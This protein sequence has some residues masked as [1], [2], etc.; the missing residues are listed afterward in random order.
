MSFNPTSLTLPKVGIIL[1]SII[2]FLFSCS[3]DTDLLLDSVLEDNPEEVVTLEDSAEPEPLVEE[4][5]EVVEEEIEP[6]IVLE[7]RTTVF[8]STQDAHTQ[9]GKGFNQQIVRLEEGNRTS[10]LMFDLTPIADIKATI[11]DVE[12]Q[13]TIVSDKGNG[14]VNVFKGDSNDWNES[15]LTDATIPDTEVLLGSITK[16]YEIGSD[17]SIDLNADEINEEIKTLILSHENG[18]DLSFASK[19]HPT[20]EGPRLVVTYDSPPDAAE[21]IIEEEEEEPVDVVDNESPIAIADATPKSGQAPLQVQFTGNNSTDDKDI[22]SYSWKIKDGVTRTNPNP[23]YTFEEVGVYEVE[24]TVTDAEGLTDI[25]TITINVT[26]EENLKPT[27]K[28]SASPLSG[29]APLEVKF[30]GDKS[31]DDMNIAS[32]K[33]R[34][35]QGEISNEVNPSFTFT[36]AGTYPVVLTVK[37]ENGLEDKANVTITVTKPQNEAPK[38][39]LGKNKASGEAPLTVRFN[40]NNSS[41]DKGIAGYVWNFGINQPSTEKIVERTFSDPGTYSVKLTVR[42]EEG[43]SDTKSTTI[44]V[45]EP[46]VQNQAP[47]AKSVPNVTSGEAP[48]TVNFKGDQSTDDDE[49]VS[50]AWNFK[51]GST[52]TNINPSHTFQNPGTYRVE[53]TVTDSDGAKN[54]DIDTITVNEPDNGGQGGSGN[55][56]PNAV[57]ASSFG[58]KAGDATEAFQ[59]AIKSNNTYIVIDKQ[60]SD[61]LIEPSRFFHLKNKTIVFEPG[62]VLRA[63]PGAYSNKTSVM[64]NF[65]ECDNINLIGN[66]ATLRMNKSEYGKSEFRHALKLDGCHDVVIQDFTIRDSGGDGININTGSR[67]R[68][69]SKNVTIENVI[70]ENNSRQGMSIISAR[71]MWVRNCEFN[72]S[73]GQL[74]EAGV[75]LEPTF[76]WEVLQNINFSNCKFKNNNGPGFT[77]EPNTLTANSASIDVKVTDCEFSNN[78]L[79][80]ANLQSKPAT[81]L[82]FGSKETGTNIVRGTALFERLSFINAKSRIIYSAK[83]ADAYE[84]IFRDCTAKNVVTSAAANPI[85]LQGKV[86]ANNLGGFDFG[87][88]R[89]EYNR[90]ISFMQLALPV[91]P[92]LKNIKGNFTI[93][94]PGDN[95]LQYNTRANPANG[96]NVNINYNHIN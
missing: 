28:A 11:T 77:I 50:Y 20:V 91:G 62:V 80:K 44:T 36:E 9:S 33:W 40:A 88:F 64:F 35:A 34:F 78:S 37:D 18:D 6:E 25:D 53:L 32:F 45:N 49:I 73:S 86:V 54:T 75:D 60:S 14:A 57:F 67:S 8:P 43:L 12:L 72:G 87:N 10:Y 16:E 68:G 79:D 39:V 2:L 66:G 96:V 52:S 27:A 93:K 29:E 56:P 92:T 69:F 31:E 90:N 48:L 30:T 83:P 89:I 70:S 13:F 82:R 85:Y 63:K 1:F 51:D 15:S 26:E 46:V 95:P 55:H 76:D 21:I 71:N 47:V 19:E 22:Q 3:R 58:F 59:D 65:Y 61:W 81:E 17:E 7:S 38:A 23:S 4:T 42:D 41:D 24:L 5:E 94:E 84:V 74:P